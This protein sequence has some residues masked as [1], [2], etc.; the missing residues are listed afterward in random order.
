MGDDVFYFWSGRTIQLLKKDKTLGNH[1][2]TNMNASATDNISL[3]P[4]IYGWNTK[5]LVDFYSREIIWDSEKN[6]R[7]EYDNIIAAA[8]RVELAS[9]S[10]MMQTSQNESGYLS[11]ED[12]YQSDRSQWAI[13]VSPDGVLCRDGEVG[14]LVAWKIEHEG[15][16]I[17]TR[18]A[19]NS[20]DFHFSRD[21]PFTA[22]FVV[23][24]FLALDACDG[25]AGI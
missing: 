16:V 22:W 21:L 23:T 6:G 25:F 3:L 19:H 12:S 1:W 2:C 5:Q 7:S 9:P 13:T 17:M 10:K 8:Q 4:G 18:N 14:D 20:T 11:N 15:K 24:S